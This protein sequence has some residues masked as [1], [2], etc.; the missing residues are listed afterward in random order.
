MNLLSQHGRTGFS[1]SGFRFSLCCPLALAVAFAFLAGPCVAQDQNAGKQQEQ[2]ASGGQPVEAQDKQAPA[3]PAGAQQPA[4]VP[5]PAPPAPND[6]AAT[7]PGNELAPAP[8]P[9]ALVRARKQ[10]QEY[11]DK[12]SDLTCKESV[13]QLVLNGSGHTIYRENSAYDYQFQTTT[14]NEIPKFIETRET[15][16]PSFRDPA[17][18]LLVTTGFANLL[19]IVHPLYE[20]SY[21][22]EPAGSETIGGVSYALIRFAPVPGA[23]SPATLRLRGRN[24]PIPMSGTLWIEPQSGTIVKLEATVGSSL[25]DLG[26]AGMRSEVHY[27]QHTFHNPEASLW[28]A[29]SAVIDVQTPHQHWRNLHHFTEYKRFSVDVHEQI[30]QLP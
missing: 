7:A 20:S 10:V 13:A 26:L 12:F 2:P 18:T 6:A 25:K 5:T 21:T 17:R 28:I 3:S 15:R 23:S 16:N 11:F 22:F 30:G 24:Y 4:A 29:D 1:L 27:A 14:Q 19:L 9:E 8:P